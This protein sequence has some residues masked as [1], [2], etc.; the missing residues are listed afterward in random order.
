MTQAEHDALENPIGSG[1]YPSLAGKTVTLK[2]VYPEQSNLSY[3]LADDY[4]L[5][6]KPVLILDKGIIR[7]K[8]DYDGRLV[9]EKTSVGNI[10]AASGVTVNTNLVAVSAYSIIGAK[11]WIQA[12]DTH[13]EK[14][15]L[16]SITPGA[17][18][19]YAQVFV[20]ASTIQIHTNSSS[21]RVGTTNNGY[22]ITVEYTKV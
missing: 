10:V 5:D 17:Y 14:I 21:E 8:Q 1:L 20:T 11:G 16:S 22:R 15:S 18:L 13:S 3:L 2:D 6:E 9:F 7:Q 19:S 12:G 4:S